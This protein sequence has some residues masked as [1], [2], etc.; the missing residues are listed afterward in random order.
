[1]RFGRLDLQTFFWEL[2]HGGGGGWWGVLESFGPF[3]TSKEIPHW[4]SYVF[5]HHPKGRIVP[6]HW[7][8][9]LILIMEP[10]LHFSVKQ[11]TV[12]WGK[13]SH[14]GGIKEQ[15]PWNLILLLCSQK[16]LKSFLFSPCCLFIYL[17]LALRG[18]LQHILENIRNVPNNFW[19]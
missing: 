7:A 16:S 2:L 11:P 10:Y 13:N 12:K 3:S 15:F 18:Y 6:I 1:M 5:I 14:T 4:D 19:V 17:L 8:V 9:L